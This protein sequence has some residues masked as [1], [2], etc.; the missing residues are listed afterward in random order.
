MTQQVPHLTNEKARIEK[1]QQLMVLDT[2]PE[3]LFDEIAKLAS[4]VCCTPIA[5]ISL[6][7]ENGLWF[8]AKVGLA[9]TKETHRSLA[10][11][12]Q[13]ILENQLLEIPDTTLDQRFASSPLV[14]AE[15]PIRFYAGA[16]LKLANGDNI[17]AISV[18]NLQPQTLTLYQKGM[19]LG[20]ANIVVDSLN[21]RPHCLKP[22]AVH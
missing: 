10:F 7:D 5:C 9:G 19:L 3:I 6:V 22:V 14:T 17:G 20:L 12:A 2:A 15:P 4:E 8:K 18:I 1:L 11:C 21:F 13:A 16:P